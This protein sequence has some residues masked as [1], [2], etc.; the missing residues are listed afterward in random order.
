MAY[1]RISPVPV[2]EGGTGVITMTTAYAPVLAGTTATGALQVASTGLAT[3]GFVLTSNGSASAPSFQ[4]A[5]GG[6]LTVTNVTNAA[7]P[8]T[9]L[10]ADQF[11]IADVTAGV[12]SILLPNT[13][14]TGR[15]VSVKDK[16]G[17]SGTNNITLT[18]VGG[19]VLIDGA[20]TYVMN[21]AYQSTSVVFNGTSYFIM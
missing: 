8:Y 20:T 1:K 21:S 18:T 12:I 4:A 15:V 14:T 11:I 9:V 10:A 19:A 13:T 2:I 6:G 17:L 5:A 16:V 3:S 7:T